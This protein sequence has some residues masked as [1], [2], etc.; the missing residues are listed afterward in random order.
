MDVPA[1]FSRSSYSDQSTISKCGTTLMTIVF[2]VQI[3]NTIYLTSSTKVDEGSNFA[4]AR[5]PNGFDEFD[6]VEKKEQT[7][8]LQINEPKKKLMQFV[9]EV[10]C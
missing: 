10:Q 4:C 1:E 2:G 7:I 6:Q 5:S 8:E 3:P 9:I